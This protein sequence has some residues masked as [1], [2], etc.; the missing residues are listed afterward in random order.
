MISLLIIMTSASISGYVYDIESKNPLTAHVLVADLNQV[1]VCDT[2]GEFIITDVR[3]GTYELIISHVG[4]EDETLSVM[5]Y[6]TDTNRLNIGLRMMPIPMEETETTTERFTLTPGRRIFEKKEMEVMPGAEKNV[7]RA[8]QIVPG[9]SSAS[10]YLGLFYVRGGELYE[11]KVLL[12]NIEIMVPYH[13]FGVGSTFSADLIKDFDFLMGAIP[14][15]YGDAISSVLLLNSIEPDR[16][17]RGMISIDL[18]EANITYN[19]RFSENISTVIGAKRNYLD[20]ILKQMGIVESVLLP[21]FFDIQGKVNVKTGLGDFFVGSLYSKDGTDIQTTIIDQTISLQMSGTSH[22]SWFGWQF[23]PSDQLHCQFHTSYGQL[24]RNVY[25]IGI[26][27]AD[28]VT[29]EHS[30]EKYGA[31]IHTEYDAGFLDVAFGGG[32]GHYDLIHSGAKIEDIFY[33]I[34]A[35]YYSLDADTTDHFGFFY[36]T[37][38]FPLLKIFEF[39]IGERLDWYPAIKNSVFSPRFKFTY[40][41]NP[42]LYFAYGFLSQTPP[43]EYPVDEYRPLQAKTI[44]LGLEYLIMPALSGKIEVYRKDYGNLIRAEN[45][46]AFDNDGEGKAIG[47]EFSLRKYRIGNYFGII[48]YA[49][50]RS[51]RTTPYDSSVVITDVHRPHILNLFIGN[52]LPGGFQIGVQAQVAAGLAYRPVIGYE[53]SY[54]WLPVYAQDKERLPYYQRIDVH[55]GKEF[56]LW[57]TWGEFYVSILN[58]TN[59]KNIQ[60]YLYNWDYTLRKAIYM[61][62]RMPLVGLR[63]EF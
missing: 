61:L 16:L 37:Q 46:T 2:L 60:G 30:I 23:T 21:Y 15:R 41:K 17:A 55:I 11:N 38:R 8:I 1:Y 14:A 12:D 3:Q 10:D 54:E 35:I 4:F 22:T 56:Q 49:Y 58:V 36:A 62:P 34:G 18:I 31:K 59:R 32:F 52:R 7:F 53:G 44:N 33:K 26:T 39:E 47:I 40:R 45:D 27:S 6:A 43:L 42:I 57:G 19:H 5:A 29:E 25:G 48:S 24:D 20:F 9:V 13:Y 50:S 51:E 63:V 28:T